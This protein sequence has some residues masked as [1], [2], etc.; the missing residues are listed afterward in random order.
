MKTKKSLE[1]AALLDRFADLVGEVGEADFA[2]LYRRHARA[3]RS[4]PDDADVESIGDDIIATL[5]VGSGTLADRYI[6]DEDGTPDV[7][8]SREYVVLVDDIRRRAKRMS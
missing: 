8:R 1:L 2:A 4:E 6:V 7:A 5:R 3:L